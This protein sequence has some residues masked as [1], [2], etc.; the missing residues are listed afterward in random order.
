MPEFALSADSR[1]MSALK[2]LKSGIFETWNREPGL[3]QALNIMKQLLSNLHP[4][5]LPSRAQFSKF[6]LKKKYLKEPDGF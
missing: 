2:A 3:Y 4:S 6:H 5:C 1:D